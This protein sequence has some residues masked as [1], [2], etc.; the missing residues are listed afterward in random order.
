VTTHDYAALAAGCP[1]LRKLTFASNSAY[2]A[3]KMEELFSYRAVTLADGFAADRRRHWQNE[4]DVNNDL[5]PDYDYYPAYSDEEY[6]WW[7]SQRRYCGAG[8]RDSHR[9]RLIE[10]DAAPNNTF[11]VSQPDVRIWIPG[12]RICESVVT[13][14]IHG[15]TSVGLLYC[16]ILSVLCIFRVVNGLCTDLNMKSKLQCVKNR[17]SL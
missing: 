16:T 3:D 7:D 13:R 15:Q 1:A 5:G 4:G 14:N 10:Q 6:P 12:V 9:N 8:E 2:H 17:V 11:E